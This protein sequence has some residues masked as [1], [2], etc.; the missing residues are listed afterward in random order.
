MS[1]LR[2]RLE[3][4]ASNAAF[5]DAPASEIARILRDAAD[6]IERD[7]EGAFGPAPLFDANGNK[8]GRFWGE[9]QR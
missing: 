1:S 7:G 2:F 4:E 9:G 8:V 5:D 6:R 3:L